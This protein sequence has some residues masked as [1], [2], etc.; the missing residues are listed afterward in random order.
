MKKKT[1]RR[2][3]HLSIDLILDI[4][5]DLDPDT[6]EGQNFLRNEYIDFLQSAEHILLDFEIGEIETE[7]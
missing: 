7:E 4:P 5:E 1:E 3:V 6:Q 2:W